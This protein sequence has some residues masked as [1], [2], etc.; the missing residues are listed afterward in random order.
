MTKTR[1]QSSSRGFRAT[2]ATA[3]LTVASLAASFGLAAAPANAKVAIPFL[4][5]GGAT[6]TVT[7]PSTAVL[8]PSGTCNISTNTTYYCVPAGTSA[9]T[10]QLTSSG[11]I[12]LPL[13]YSATNSSTGPGQFTTVP[14]SVTLTPANSNAGQQMT[15]SVG[16]TQVVTVYFTQQTPTIRFTANPFSFNAGTIATI[17]GTVVDQTGAPISGA[18]VSGQI[19]A[20]AN[21]GYQSVGSGTTNAQG[22]FAITY[23]DARSTATNNED[24]VQVTAVTPA[25][26]QTQANVYVQWQNAIGTGN[27]SN[28]LF[29]GVAASGFGGALQVAAQGPLIV[30][31]NTVAVSVVAPF[32]NSAVTFTTSGG[33]MLVAPNGQEGQGTKSLTLNASGTTATVW[34]FSTQAGSMPVTAS[35]GNAL[36]GS[37]NFQA[38]AATARNVS[39]TTSSAA[40]PA[41][42][43]FNAIATVTDGFGNPVGAGVPINF[44]VNSAVGTFAGG[45]KFTTGVT[46]QA[47]QAIA[48]VST[49]ASQSGAVVLSASGGG[50]QFGL[51]A[52]NPVPFFGNSTPSAGAQ[53]TLTAG[54]VGQLATVQAPSSVKPKKPFTVKAAHFPAGQQLQFTLNRGNKV[55]ASKYVATSNTGYAQTTFTATQAGTY[56]VIATATSEPTTANKQIKVK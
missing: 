36:T 48:Q 29:N 2:L 35:S 15:L 31:Q 39:L 18:R 8:G 38:S 26:V 50:Y 6:V 53:V 41:G 4:G 7:A 3:A 55:V 32:P 19:V 34:F 33:G 45:A 16:L 14:Q 27:L 43:T 21:Y 37:I 40:A 1:T 42:S 49:A 9:I 10:F 24:N 13:P 28:L 11:G 17:T 22:Q 46:N 12:E 56:R 20:G 54:G 44:A 25:G 51:P 23:N 30:G 5:V 52:A 47:G